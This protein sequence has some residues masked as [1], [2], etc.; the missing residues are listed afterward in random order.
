MAL[1]FSQISAITHPMINE[2][3]ADNFFNSN[4]LFVHLKEVGSV[5]IDG[6]DNIQLPIFYDD[7]NAAGSFQNYDILDTTPND[8][9]NAAKY[10]WRREYAQVIISRHEML[11]NSGKSAIKNLLKAKVKNS[12]MTLKNNLG[13]RIFSTNGDSSLAVNGLRQIVKATGAI[14]NVDQSDF[15]GWASTINSSDA[16]LTILLMQKLFA[17]VQL[18]D[19]VPDIAVTTKFVYNKYYDLLQSA[20]RFSEAKVGKGGF[21]YLMFNE[22][23]IFWDSHCPG[24]SATGDNHL[25]M[26][27]SEWLYLY[28]HSGDNFLVEKVGPLANQDVHIERITFTG[29]LATD[30]RRLHGA[31]TVL[32]H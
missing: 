15:S 21:R 16:T 2:S 23:P 10:E 4:P 3:I 27:N 6:G 1:P 13:T 5:V 11:R 19:E 28:I 8:N 31:F 9:V 29:Q 26:L 12:V 20:Q 30:N 14:G 32:N 25:F 24:T 7:T 18:G 22:I 17:N